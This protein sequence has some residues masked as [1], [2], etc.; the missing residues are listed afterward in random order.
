MAAAEF[1]R[2]LVSTAVVQAG[3]L[4]LNFELLDCPQEMAFSFNRS[5]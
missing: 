4:T 1:F 3:A 5:L 2:G